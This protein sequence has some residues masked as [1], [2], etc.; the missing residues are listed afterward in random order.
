MGKIL[1]QNTT[2]ADYGGGW[3]IADSD[4]NMASR[5]QP[6]SEN[7]IR[8]ITGSF[9]PRWGTQ[10]FCD[11]HA[12]IV[13]SYTGQTLAYALVAG[14]P[15]YTVTKAAHG[16]TNGQHITITAVTRT[17]VTGSIPQ[18]DLIGTHGIV[19]VDANTF[20]FSVRTA[21]AA[22]GAGSFTAMSYSTDNYTLG[23]NIIHMQYFN[24]NMVVFDDMGEVAR[25]DDATGIATRIWSMSFANS[26]AG[27][28]VGSRRC[29]TWSSTTFK[30]TIIAC[31]GYDRDKPIQ[32]NEAFG[33]EFLVDKSTSSNGN[34]PCADIVLGM[35][36]YVIFVRTAS[37]GNTDVGDPFVCF[38]ALNT[39][40]TFSGEPAPQDAV[41]KDLSM[42]TD[43]VNPILLGAAP[44]RDKIFVAFYDR[45]MI[46]TLGIYNDADEHEPDFSDTISEHGTVS[47]RTLVPLGND[48]FMA[49][50]AGVPSISIS[51]QSGSFVPVRVSELIGPEIQ[52]HLANLQEETL[53]IKSFALFNKSDRQY[54]LF[55]PKYDEVVQALPKDPFLFSAEL[56][57]NNQALL[58]APNHKLFTR[59]F[60]TI[61]GASAIG[62]L[63][64]ANIN[65]KRAVVAIIDKDTVVV[66]LG[67]HP[68]AEQPA[69]GGG[70]A[71]TITP[72]N[73]ETICYAFE[74]NK[75]LKIKR[76]TRLRDMN[77]ACGAATQR[78]RIYFAKAGRVFRYG[79]NDEPLYAD[80]VS[81]YDVRT[82]TVSTSYTAGT[83]VYDSSDLHTY[84]CTVSHTSPSTGTFAQARAANLDSWEEYQGETIDWELETPWSDLQKRANNKNMKYVAHDSEGT[85]QFTFS[86]FTN[87]SYRHPL[88]YALSPKR[89]VQ[90]SAGRVG[91]YGMIDPQTWGTGRRTRE[92]RV[93]PMP[94]KGKLFR[95]RYEG[96]TRDPVRVISTTLFY[97]MGGI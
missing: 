28:P 78:G 82:W 83:R 48:I 77:W 16:L 71:V 4:L 97:L 33:V 86:I 12:G 53:R 44:F 21:S 6:V 38:S 47:H 46:G 73:D 35:Q 51:T 5:F 22:T 72:I 3:N 66:Q 81:N 67:D 94:C 30:S 17:G 11:L 55:L 96:Q 15:T 69:Y 18:T 40:G 63:T 26:L 91:G 50:Y 19:V 84:I 60:I 89:T 88:S 56:K 29:D 7:V 41:D 49:D 74:Y 10:L 80:E 95:L 9:S 65:G 32:I 87:Q 64:P 54:M 25:I 36:G 27:A 8:G 23:G 1:L 43:T 61:A 52:R 68:I 14:S 76:W 62:T 75:E 45:G 20:K 70:T 57:T 13:T 85:G 42:I 34:V 79:N 37:G 58:I 92:E 31:N 90:F 59:S 24:K 39:D 2:I 93:W